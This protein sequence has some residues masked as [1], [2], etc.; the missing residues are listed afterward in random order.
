MRGEKKKTK[1]ELKIHDCTRS[2]HMTSLIEE[3]IRSTRGYYAQ[4]IMDMSLN[5]IHLS[6]FPPIAS[7][8]VYDHAR[9]RRYY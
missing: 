4:M 7:C 2:Y 1:A 9:V 3:I 8:H 5:N 6:Y